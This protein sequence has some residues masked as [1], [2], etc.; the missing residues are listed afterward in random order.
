MTDN[1]SQSVSQPIDFYKG[2]LSKREICG[3]IIRIDGRLQAHTWNRYTAAARCYFLCLSV[4]V[5]AIRTFTFSF[6]LFYLLVSI[7]NYS[8]QHSFI[9]RAMLIYALLH[10]GTQKHYAH[11][12]HCTVYVFSY[13]DER[14]SVAVNVFA[15]FHVTPFL[16]AIQHISISPLLDNSAPFVQYITA[17][18]IAYFGSIFFFNFLFF[19]LPKVFGRK[20]LVSKLYLYNALDDTINHKMIAAL[21]RPNVISWAIHSRSSDSFFSVFF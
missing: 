20:W 17:T 7:S 2:N 11:I 1:H 5:C 9:F 8:Q 15:P 14:Y 12:V 10:A 4:I 21:H 3:Q 6:F 18:S 19:Y 16:F 13:F